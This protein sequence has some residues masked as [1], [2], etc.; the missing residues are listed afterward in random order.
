[1]L[2]NPSDPR[3]RKL[4]EGR[5]HYN[6]E[7]MAANILLERVI[8]SVNQDNSEPNLQLAVQETYQFFARYRSI[9]ENDIVHLF[10]N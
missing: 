5:I 2:P 10:D 9:L 3:W 8:Q 7:L 1:M 6:C 4:V